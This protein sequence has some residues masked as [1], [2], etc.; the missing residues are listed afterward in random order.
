MLDH[1]RLKP[2]GL[3]ANYA[4]CGTSF[5]RNDV[6]ALFMSHYLGEP[7]QSIYSRGHVPQRSL[8]QLM[9]KRSSGK[10]PE[11]VFEEIP[12]HLVIRQGAKSSKWSPHRYSREIFGNY[13]PKRVF[14][15]AIPV[16][17]S[18]KRFTY[19]EP[20]SIDK[21]RK[22]M[23]LPESWIFHS[24]G[25]ALELAL[26]F[27]LLSGEL[28]L[29]LH[30]DDFVIDVPCQPGRSR[31]VLPIAQSKPGAKAIDLFVKPLAKGSPTRFVIHGLTPVS[32]VDTQTERIP[33][34]QAPTFSKV[35]ARQELVF[36]AGTKV[37]SL[38]TLLMRS[39][40]GVGNWKDIS[41][42]VLSE[43]G[44]IA[45]E[46]ETPILRR[47]GWIVLVPGLLQGRNIGKVL[48][49]GVYA[50]KGR[51]ETWVV[52]ARLVDVFQTK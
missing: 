43:D 36:P 14:P 30:Y 19:G 11:V 38:T 48:L 5:S 27:E 22:I 50:G 51:T 4:L 39:E 8:A 23:R 25:G 32:S 26:D 12:N 9:E 42:Q 17:L 7:V 31:Y 46:F 10:N 41:I 20:L 33:E 15:L 28:A 21:A 18:A 13:V 37:S 1:S 29:S 6:F 52:D 40:S 44:S 2:G 49:Q 45:Q 24:G 47:G 3:T 16:D 34:I 35:Q